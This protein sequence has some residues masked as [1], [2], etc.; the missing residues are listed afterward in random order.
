MEALRI[1]KAMEEMADDME[2]ERKPNKKLKDVGPKT[3]VPET[4]EEKEPKKKGPPTLPVK[5][6]VRLPASV[7]RVG[8][9]A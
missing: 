6:V 7:P 2:R 9:C 8:E 3:T 4:V 5:E 1:R